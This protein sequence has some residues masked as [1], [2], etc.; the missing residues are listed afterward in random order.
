MEVKRQ[1]VQWSAVALLLVNMIYGASHVLAKGV[2]PQY[3]SPTVF[4]G[5]RVFGALLLFWGFSFF[6]HRIPIERNDLPRLIACGLFGIT[7]N[8]LLFFQGLNASSPMNAGI[9]MAINPIMVAV[10][11]FFWLGERLVLKQWFGILIGSIGATALTVYGSSTF[12][13]RLGDW[14]LFG[15]SLSYAVYLILVKPLMAKY[16]PIQVITWVFT[17]GSIFLLMYP[18]LYFDLAET[19]FNPIPTDAWLKI[20]FVVVAVTFITYLLTVIGLKYVSS[21]IA[22]VFIYVQPIFVVGFT[23]LFAAI[24]WSK[25]YTRSINFTT[26]CFM[27]IVFIGVFL[28]KSS[29]A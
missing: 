29:K 8:Q 19:S 15:N 5:F 4:I 28:S 1:K 21:T 9:I 17:F 7:V 14:L 12:E 3:L 20:I 13:A 23:F 25:D 24:G 18:P 2:M 10:L 22:S 27:I 16:P 26:L 11:S 6:I